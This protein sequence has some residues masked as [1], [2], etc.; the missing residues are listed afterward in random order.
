MKMW[1]KSNSKYYVIRRKDKRPAAYKK[2]KDL[3]KDTKYTATLIKDK[4]PKDLGLILQELYDYK[5]DE[6]FIG[7]HRTCT[8]KNFIFKN[9]IKYGDSTE[10]DNH[11]QVF[12][13]LVHMLSEII[14][15]E[16]YKG[17][18]GCIIVKIPK[19]DIRKEYANEKS[20][21]IFYTDSDGDLYLKP[22]YVAGYVRVGLSTIKSVEFN[23]LK[24]DDI[25]NENTKYFFDENIKKNDYVKRSL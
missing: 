11:V 2:L 23:T 5:N 3:R 12:N 25:Y 16:S 4:I 21:E 7:I 6:Y 9:G 14:D 17:S 24:H 10:F 8:D 22:E 19:K 1:N 15:C 13:D 18:V 20:E